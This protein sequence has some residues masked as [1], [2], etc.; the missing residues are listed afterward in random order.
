MARL[1][2]TDKILEVGATVMKARRKSAKKLPATPARRSTRDAI[3]NEASHELN[4]RGVS[5]ETLRR[6]AQKLGITREA[7]YYYF[8]DRNDLVSHCYLET[9]QT[10]NLHLDGV[11]ASSSTE[12]ERIHRFIDD[13]L[14]DDALELC[15]PINLG[16]MDEVRR[17]MV[18]QAIDEL[19][20]KLAELLKRGIDLGEF[21]ACKTGVAA[22]AIVSL[23]L[24]QPFVNLVPSGGP[25]ASRQAYREFIKS[26]ILKGTAADRSAMPPYEEIDFKAPEGSAAQAFDRIWITDV[27]RAAILSTASRLFNEKGVDTTTLDE[28]ASQFGATTG[29]L[30]HHIGDKET[31]V[32]QCYLRAYQLSLFIIDRALEQPGSRLGAI[33]AFEQAWTQAQMRKD[34]APM[35][36]LASFEALSASSKGQIQNMSQQFGARWRK[37]AGDALAAREYRKIDLDILQRTLP[38]LSNWLVRMETGDLENQRSIGRELGVFLTLGIG[39]LPGAAADLRPPT[40]LSARPGY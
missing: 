37:L 35:S 14:A 33:A 32:T 24:W 4:R 30:Y 40:S 23:I 12:T 11:L 39:A 20:E 31:L 7:L 13:V 19:F 26:L 36:Q 27:K 1:R 29:A 16:M 21:R 28:I 15:G 25:K 8:K 2:L 6:I 38:G 22:P 5:L 18:V 34:V 17:R 3:L 9:A 10:L